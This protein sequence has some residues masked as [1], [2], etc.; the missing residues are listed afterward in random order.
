MTLAGPQVTA[1]TFT[2]DLTTVAS[3]ES[4]RDGQFRGRIM[5]VAQYP[6]AT[7]VLS[8]PID[9]GTVPA[10]GATVTATAKGRLTVKG[11][12]RD[13]TFD[14][15]AKRAGG[16]ITVAG[17]IPVVFADYGIDNPSGGPAQTEDHGEVE[18]RLQ[19]AKQ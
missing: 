1:G 4:R 16:A 3:D 9:L 6:T 11:V 18:F 8:S 5:N 17:A 15:Q 19:L 10:E 14:V 13:V 7:F 12:T 2:V